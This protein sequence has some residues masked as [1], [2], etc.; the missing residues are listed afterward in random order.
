MGSI[1]KASGTLHGQFAIQGTMD[2]P[3]V[4]GELNFNK[5]M[6]IPAALSSPL[7]IDQQKIRITNEGIVFNKF[8]I[9]DSASNSAQLDGTAYTTNFSNYK[10]DLLFNANNFQALNSTRKDNNL[11]YG[12][13]FFNSRLNIKG[14]ELHPII[15]GTLKVNEKPNSPSYCLRTIPAYRTAK[16]LCVL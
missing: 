11:Y 2:K 7:K 6:L 8:T 13:L 4:D 1:K 12:D 9:R 10:F 5:A 15:D 14:T 3:S 16:A